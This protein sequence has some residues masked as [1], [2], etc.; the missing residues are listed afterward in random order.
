MSITDKQSKFPI[1]PL[2][3]LVG[4]L[5]AISVIAFIS[6]SPILSQNTSVGDIEQAEI[7]VEKYLAK[8]G[9]DFEIE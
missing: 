3:V 9:D 7:I 5:V 4:G 6:F 2:L 1:T 8:L